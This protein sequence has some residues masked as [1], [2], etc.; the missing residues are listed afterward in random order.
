[1]KKQARNLLILL[2]LILVLSPD[3]LRAQ[4]FEAVG[5]TYPVK[6]KPEEVGAV[7]V[8]FDLLPTTMSFDLPWTYCM[9]TEN[10]IKFANLAAETYDPR[11]FDGTG[12]LA[13]F[14]PGMDD[15][16]RYVRAWIEHQSDAR[17]V[18]R[19]RYALN[20]NLY[21]IAHPDI[22]SGSPYGK[23]DWT[24]EWHYIYPDGTNIRHM[25]IYTGLAPVSRPFGF[26][27]EPPSTVHEF[28]ESVVI[29]Q[30]GHIPTDDIEIDALT[31]IRMFGGHSEELIEE[32][33]ST[34]ISFKPYPEDYGEF[35]DA[36]V[37][38][39]NLKSEYKPFIIAMPYGVRMQPYMPEDDLPFVFQTWGSPP[40][41]GYATAF[42]HIINYWH[43]RRTDNVLEQIY[44][45]GM[46]NNSDPQEELVS[47]AW[48]WITDPPLRMD[49]LEDQ[50]GVYTYDPA[51][52]AYIVPRKG[53]GPVR[54]EWMLDEPEDGPMN[55]INP[56]FIVKDWDVEGVEL[57]MNGK[58]VEP[59]RDFRVGYE[60]T[61]TGSDLVLWIRMHAREAV[62]F[63]LSPLPK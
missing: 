13:S 49:G 40:E 39:F 32:G 12:G 10:N 4:K 20:N 18:V 6:Q 19:V 21:D 24:D 42:G 23:G 16:G 63:E 22:P 36:N 47:L 56:A 9:V 30:R 15:E 44:L 50:Y 41:R 5:P 29:G 59:G 37:V 7:K 45:S 60:D 53:R 33:I 25:R 14:E 57:K 51:Q 58:H 52:K 27:R 17:I 61:P 38:L 26:N 1:M 35:R 34:T 28:M 54:L 62:E 2:F 55:I 3:N 43:Y 11:D 31:L 46:T 48:S 8:N